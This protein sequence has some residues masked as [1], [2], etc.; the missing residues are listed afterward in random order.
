MSRI[1]HPQYLLTEGKKRPSTDCVFA[2]PLIEGRL[3]EYDTHPKFPASKEEEK[4]GE[5][6]TANSP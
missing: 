5:M 6:E 2:A 4:M 3:P 1:H